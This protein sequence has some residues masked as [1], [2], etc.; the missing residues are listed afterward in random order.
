MMDDNTKVTQFFE[1]VA[2]SASSKRERD[3]STTGESPETERTAL[4]DSETGLL[5]LDALTG[6]PPWGSVMLRM[7]KKM[8]GCVEQVYDKIDSFRR[9]LPNE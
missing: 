8:M 6:L 2:P 4:G 1:K 9:S 5:D 7:L 3:E